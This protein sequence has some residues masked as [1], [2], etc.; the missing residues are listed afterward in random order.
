VQFSIIS[1]VMQRADGRILVFDS[2][3]PAIYLFD[4][5]GTF[6]RQVGRAGDG[7]D[8]YRFPRLVQ[9]LADDQ[10]VVSDGARH[11]LFVLDSAL[12]FGG[13]QGRGGVTKGLIWTPVG[14]LADGTGV[15][16]FTSYPPF[17]PPGRLDS[18]PSVIALISPTGQPTDTLGRFI[19]GTQWLNKLIR[20]KYQGRGPQRFA[21]ALH[22]VT[23]GTCVYALEGRRARIIR[24]HVRAARVDTLEWAASPAPLPRKDRE[25][26][27]RTFMAMKTDPEVWADVEFSPTKPVL[28]APLIDREG[29]L[30]AITASSP[31]G[32]SPDSAFVFDTTGRRVAIVTFPEHFTPREIGADYVIGQRYDDDGVPIIVRFPLRK[33][34]VLAEGPARH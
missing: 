9:R 25:T 27:R 8:E 7:P 18:L 32:V 2:Q 34:A 33:S 1:G 28:G 12:R 17:G 13:V 5:Q 10:V 23:D 3:V 14:V 19:D 31:F 4:A 16:K 6:V 29:N 30:W 26:V 20:G 22:A 15:A 11:R 24:Y 21:W